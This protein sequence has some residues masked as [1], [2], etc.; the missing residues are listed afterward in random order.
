MTVHYNRHRR[1]FLAA[2]LT[3][4]VVL[5]AGPGKAGAQALCP[6][7]NYILAV[8]SDLDC[9]VKLC[10]GVSPLGPI[11]CNYYA[12]GTKLSIPCF[13]GQV[14]LV[15]RCDGTTFDLLDPSV[16][17][18][19]NFKVTATCCAR[20]CISADAAGCLRFEISGIPCA[21]DVCP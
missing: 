20:A 2:A 15:E 12:P 19:T 3:A 18:C 7:S 5:F 6:C 10:W 11:T 9:K 13:T 21:T 1:F 8:N 16:A 4:L 14:I 17:R